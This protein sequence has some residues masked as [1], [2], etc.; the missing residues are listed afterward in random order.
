MLK[1]SYNTSFRS[2]HHRFLNVGRYNTHIFNEVPANVLLQK[3][4]WGNEAF[5]FF[6]WWF[7]L[8]QIFFLQ[9]LKIRVSKMLVQYCFLHHA[10]SFVLL[11]VFYSRICF[12]VFV[13]YCLFPFRGETVKKKHGNI[14]KCECMSYI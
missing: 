1:Y 10:N 2:F 5:L 12:F 4:I 6:L 9:P 11:L 7:F 8:V 13:F 14:Y 3:R